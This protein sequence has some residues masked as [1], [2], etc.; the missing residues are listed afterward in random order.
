M[1]TSTT[2]EDSHSFNVAFFI[3]ASLLTLNW[4]FL[5]GVVKDHFIE[6][7]N[8]KELRSHQI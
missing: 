1:P 3:H 8:D 6:A 4:K 5:R 2:S 7:I